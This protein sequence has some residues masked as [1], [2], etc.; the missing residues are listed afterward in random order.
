MAFRLFPITAFPATEGKVYPDVFRTNTNNFWLEGLGVMASLDADAELHYVF[1]VPTPLPS[2]TAK[3]EV[4]AMTHDS[5]NGDATFNPHWKSIAVGE[6]FD[7]TA[8][9]LLAEGTET[10]TWV[11]NE[12]CLFKGAKV[13]LDADTLVADEFLA[14]RL[15]LESTNWT[16]DE[17]SLWIA[18]VIWE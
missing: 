7:L 5:G 18:S 4:L 12:G 3:L 15:V 16:L 14:L 9:S 2:G 6:D 17:R 8:A 1:H 10:L 13:T 11:T